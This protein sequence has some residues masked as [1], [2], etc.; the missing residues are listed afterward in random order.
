MSIG[1]VEKDIRKIKEEFSSISPGRATGGEPVQEKK[2]SHSI[3][4]V[5]AIV[6]LILA[7]LA[8]ALFFL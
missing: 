7:L 8:L 1:K 5:A 4:I 3:V 6:I 2:G